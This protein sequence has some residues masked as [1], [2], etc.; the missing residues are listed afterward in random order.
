M[1]VSSTPNRWVRYLVFGAAGLLLLVMGAALRPVLIPAS[2]TDSEGV[3][4]SAVDIGFAQDMSVHHEQA[5]F[6]SQNLDDNVSPVVY[7]LAQQIIAKQTAEIGTLRGWLMLVDAPLSS[8]D[9][10]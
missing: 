4:L 2:S 9:P 7:Q 1:T 3:S 10:M 6:I 5:L 8:A